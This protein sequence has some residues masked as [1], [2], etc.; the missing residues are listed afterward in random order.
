MGSLR[1]P[2]RAI[3]GLL[4]VVAVGSLV[5]PLLALIG[6]ADWPHFLTDITSPTA[7]SA[8]RLSL[9]SAA[10]AT[11]ISLLLGV[12]LALYLAR[13]D[14]HLA[15]GT[16]LVVNLPLVLP[17]LVGGLALLMLLGRRGW[18][19]SYL[20][21]Y[22]DLQIAFTTPA[23][24]VAQ[25]FVALPFMVLTVEGV[26]RSIPVDQEMVAASLGA[27][28][29][30]VFW[31]VTIPLLRPGL[32]AGSVLSFSRALGEF[33]ATALFAGNRPGVTQTMPLAIYTAFN[34]GGVSASAA[35]ALAL[36][37]MAASAAVLAFTAAPGVRGGRRGRQ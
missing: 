31:K 36:L 24:V 13:S 14:S 12:P 15:R 25:V 11:L 20:Y 34:G 29:S 4:S 5:L 17:P 18:L 10:T 7:I 1:V 8:L 26:A 28:P 19:G 27:S 37:L 23:V 30:Q 33:G 2:G 22:F 16:S 3:V 21:E 6:S 9:F 35:V 32:I